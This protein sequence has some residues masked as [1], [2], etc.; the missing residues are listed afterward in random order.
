MEEVKEENKAR[1]SKEYFE[2]KKSRIKDLGRDAGE[3]IFL[4]YSLEATQM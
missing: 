4:K 1:T 3:N 2:G